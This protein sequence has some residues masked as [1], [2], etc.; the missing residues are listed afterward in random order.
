MVLKVVINKTL[1]YYETLGIREVERYPIHWT[2]EMVMKEVYNS[3]WA[4]LGVE[5]AVITIG[6]YRCLLCPL[7]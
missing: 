3:K 7:E 1:D 2:E 4:E 5:L 6:Q